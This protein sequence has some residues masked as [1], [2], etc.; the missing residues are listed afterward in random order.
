MRISILGSRGYPSTYGGFETFVR[1]LAPWLVKRAHEVTVYGRSQGRA[2]S[3]IVDGV[4]VVETLGTS[5]KALS[6]A[7]HGFTAAL[8][9]A[10]KRPD[11]VLALNVANGPSIALLKASGVPVVLN[12]DGM[13]WQRDKWG[14]TAKRA[15]RFG[16]S[17]AARYATELV[18][19]SQE[20]ARIWHRDFGRAPTYIP[21]GADVVTTTSSDRIRSM[22]LEPGAYALAV[23]RLA[24]ENNVEMFVDALASLNYSVPAV[25]VGSANYDNPL[26]ERLRRLHSRKDIQWL[27]HVSDQGLLSELWSHA[28]VYF[29]GHSV[30]GTNPA[31]LQALGHGAPTIALDTPYN[32]E[33]VPGPDFLVQGDVKQIANEILAHTRNES[34]R[35]EKTL[36]G[37]HEVH[38]R[39]AWQDV[40]KSYERALIAATSPSD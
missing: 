40:L 34:L 36:R 11:V 28:G 26:E 18:A 9:A 7:T 17:A 2:N 5:S 24:P 3:Y 10:R 16:A 20:I 8:H 13:E 27:G 14:P 35:C 22:D 15:F 25:V 6:T 4:H 21:Y 31:L 32:R 39:F 30:G 1:H 29:H 19:D 33:V 12:V 37:Q 23:A 38:T